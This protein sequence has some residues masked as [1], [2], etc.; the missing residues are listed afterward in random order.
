MSTADFLAAKTG[1]YYD[2]ACR[3]KKSYYCLAVA[4]DHAYHFSQKFGNKQIPYKC[5]FCGQ[6]HL[7]TEKIVQKDRTQVGV[8]DM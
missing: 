2:R 8:C 6:Y 4:L 7:R 5:P 1:T 3:F